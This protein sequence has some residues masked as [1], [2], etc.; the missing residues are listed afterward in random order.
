MGRDEE[1]VPG[2]EAGFPAVR[3]FHLAGPREDGEPLVLLLVVPEAGRGAVPARDDALDPRAGPLPE[4]G[5]LLLR[6]E[7]RGRGEEVHTRSSS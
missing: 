5:K 2:R 1:G 4:D 6:A 3:E 7:G